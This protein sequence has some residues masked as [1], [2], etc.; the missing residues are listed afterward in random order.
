M[1]AGALLG[2]IV[3]GGAYV[4]G[5]TLFGTTLIASMVTGASLGHSLFGRRSGRAAPTISPR[6]DFE[7]LHNTRSQA[8]PVPIIYG[9]NRV[10]GNVIYQR[11]SDDK[12]RLYMAVGL[13]EGPIE[14][15]RE[16]RI[17][18]EPV[19]AAE[20]TIK[21]VS[22]NPPVVRGRAVATIR[23]RQGF[24]GGVTVTWTFDIL[25]RPVG[26]GAWLDGGQTVTTASHG[27]VLWG[28]EYRT[29]TS[30]WS[31]TLTGASGEYDVRV[32]L[33]SVTLSNSNWE[34]WGDSHRVDVNPTW[35]WYL[36]T[37]DQQ[38]SVWVHTGE[39]WKYTA[40]V[41]VHVRD[42]AS[43][44]GRIPTVTSV[45]DGLRVP[46]WDPALNQWIVEHT[47]NP[48]WCLLD[49]LRNTRYGV[50]VPDERIDF[51]SFKEEAEYC[52]ELVDDGQGGQEARFR[53]D[54]VIDAERPALDII[55][56]ILATFRGFLVYSDGKIRLRIEKSEPPVYS[57]G[58]HNIVADSF[59]FS[60]AARRDIP[61]QIRVEWIDPDSDYER[62]EAVY[63]NE[64]DQDER[65]E[66]VSR[67]ISL[68]GI[69]RPGQA[70]RMARFYHDKAYWCSTACEFRVG[71][72]A[73]HV[74]VGDVVL[75]SHDVPGWVDKP[76]R[77]VQI[78]EAE[79]DEMKLTCIEYRSD[80]Y[81]DRGSAYQPSKRTEL[82]SP[83]DPPPAPE[84][85]TLSTYYYDGAAQIIA[86]WDPVPFLGDVRYEVRY[87]RASTSV[88][89]TVTVDE[90]T[91][92][93]VPVPPERSYVFQVRAIAVRTN[94]AGDWSEDETIVTA[95]DAEGL[96]PSPILLP[97]PDLFPEG[98]D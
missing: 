41:A 25:Y 11:I 40:Y 30:N 70:G 3:A 7:E 62:V 59:V 81:H 69:S 49:F 27:T 85:L 44:G 77:V 67:T 9:T 57:F 91:Y 47:R 90:T 80:I 95:S 63:D 22:G 96:Y 84:G 55:D 31:H 73:L 46:V 65:G 48:V 97:T 83:F 28:D 14:A 89:S 21:R 68:L 33:R 61:N 18:D 98:D 94:L 86:S 5:S 53:L 12:K 72:D 42:A 66:V 36:G 38:P 20:D 87:R 78:E 50:G 34:L 76:F 23:S 17:N 8:L 58:M 10:A 71:I 54:Y 93:V 88:W 15:V 43:V 79:N 60:K 19:E 75:V 16:I 39:A 45:V 32:E 37:S 6:Y 1:G 24:P 51:E 35:E 26:S 82:P 92:I 13:G 64:S 74:E 56:D 2:A 4:A 52:E 29:L